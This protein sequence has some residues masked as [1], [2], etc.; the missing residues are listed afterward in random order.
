M[1]VTNGTVPGYTTYADVGYL[2][3]GVNAFIVVLSVLSLIAIIIF[4]NYEPVKSRRV[5]SFV[6]LLVIALCSGKNCGTWVLQGEKLA[7]SASVELGLLSKFL[8]KNS[9]M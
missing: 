1:N 4:R 2:T 6:V 7:V 8:H 9:H 3:L 5:I